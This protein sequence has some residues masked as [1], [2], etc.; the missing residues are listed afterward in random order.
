[1]STVPARNALLNLGFR[2]FYLLASVF[3]A[4]SVLLWTAQASGHLDF[5]YL[6]GAAWHGHEML[7][8]FTIAVIAGFLLTAVR[9][10][11]NEPTPTGWPLLALALLWVFGRVLVMTPFAMVAA[12][13][14]AAFP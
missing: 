1:M 11:T 4:V 13:V 12:I 6:Q 9:A 3:S 14:N 2:P 8:G 7:F 5:A 10:W